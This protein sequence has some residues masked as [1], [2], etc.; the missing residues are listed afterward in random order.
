MDFESLFSSHKLNLCVLSTAKSSKL[1]PR[2]AFCL[3]KA[4][5][6]T[7]TRP[8]S[9]ISQKRGV[10][11][12]ALVEQRT[13][14]I[15]IFSFLRCLGCVDSVHAVRVNPKIPFSSPLT[16]LNTTSVVRD[17]TLC[18]LLEDY[19]HFNAHLWFQWGHQPYCLV[20][21]STTFKK[22]PQSVAGS[23][24]GHL[25]AIVSS[26]LVFGRFGANQRQSAW[27]TVKRF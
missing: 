5:K 2:E 9:E 19:V 27:L 23:M 12:V 1:Q 16:T 17:K 20:R 21:N 25:L 18:P 13:S 11:L 6:N 8:F 22:W 4:Q 10:V 14:E 7:V 26:F 3:L 24:G 15:T